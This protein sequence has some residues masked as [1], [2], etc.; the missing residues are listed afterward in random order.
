VIHVVSGMWVNN[1]CCTFY[2]FNFWTLYVCYS[3]IL[4]VCLLSENVCDS[5][6]LSSVIAAQFAA[7][8]FFKQ[9]YSVSR[10]YTDSAKFKNWWQVF[11]LIVIFH[12]ILKYDCC[13]MFYPQPDDLLCHG[14]REPT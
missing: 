5:L 2:L 12:H 8:K 6:V 9:D 10:K 7:I 13:F 1:T 4:N 14:D 11:V 3:I